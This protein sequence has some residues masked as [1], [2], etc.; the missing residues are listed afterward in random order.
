MTSQ[1]SSANLGRF[2]SIEGGE[3]CGKS[4]QIKQIANRL[5]SIGIDVIITREPGGTDNAEAIRELLLSGGDNRWDSRAEALLFAAARGDHVRNLIKPALMRGQWVLCDRFLESSRAYQSGGSGLSDA[6]ILQLHEIGSE[7]FLPDRVLVL[8]L[9]EDAANERVS[10]RDGDVRD[11]IGGRPKIFHT[12][13]R[14]AFRS[15]AEQDSERIKL[16]NA[17]AAVDEVTNSIIDVLQ[18]MIDA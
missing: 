1:N 11:R 17:S 6:T 4:T 18:D 7:G 16:I 5:S 12:A 9:D 15:Y 3:G 10:M 2:I 8:D 14:Q 13:V